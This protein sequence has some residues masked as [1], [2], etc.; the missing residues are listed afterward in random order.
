MSPHIWSQ[1]RLLSE[2]AS[3]FHTPFASAPA[4]RTL[5]DPQQ[6]L[7]KIGVHQPAHAAA[8]A[9]AAPDRSTQ[10]SSVLANIEDFYP[11]RDAV[12]DM[13]EGLRVAGHNQLSPL[14][15]AGTGASARL[16]PMGSGRGDESLRRTP[17]AGLVPSEASVDGVRQ[18]YRQ[19]HAEYVELQVRVRCPYLD[20]I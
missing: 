2:R 8:A 1:P 9:A 6:R 7:A 11:N 5:A 13:Y 12:F 14:A 19:L 3:S 15:G 10:A 18:A 16:S 20:P 17:F 4:Q